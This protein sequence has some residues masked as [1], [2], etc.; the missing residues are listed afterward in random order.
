MDSKREKIEEIKKDIRRWNKEGFVIDEIYNALKERNAKK[1]IEVYKK[2]KRLVP[3]IERYIEI[4][5]NYHDPESREIMEILKNPIEYERNEDKIKDFIKR[6]ESV[7]KKEEEIFD[8]IT[9]VKSE[10]MESGLNPL[11]TFEN[12]VVYEGNKLAYTAAKKILEELG[13]INPLIIM[14]SNGTG[15]THLL[16]AIG[17]EYIKR[18]RVTYMNSEEILL[19][20]NVDLS[21]DLLLLDDFHLLLEKEDKH[22]L[23]N[24][25]FENFLKKGKQ[26]VL[27]TNFEISH[28]PL[29]PSLRAK[30]ESGI[31]IKLNSPDK[32]IRVSILKT[33]A[34][35]MKVDLNEDIIFYLSKNISN[36]SRLVSS[37]KKLIAFSKILGEKPTISMAG[38]IIKSKIYLSSGIS[39]LVEEEKPYRSI[40]YLKEGVERDYNAICITRMNPERFKKTFDINAEV[41]WLTDHTT[42]LPSIKPILE[43]IN[44][45]L[46]R[47]IKKKYII[48]LDGLDFL[49][50]KNSGDA[51]IQFIRHFID[52]LSESN[53]ILIISLNPQT[54]EE[55]YLKILEREMEI[56]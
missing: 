3:E 26:I 32:K 21:A 2:Y 8:L 47:Y 35:E 19:G 28:Y 6:R 13:S 53:S 1:F 44:F 42:E 36:L 4:I 9:G 20:K 17:N 7:K 14:G 34:K 41:Y 54:I 18:G 24:L 16:N 56:I 25:I 5:K 38:E 52:I 50:S 51:V 43:N 33:K 39:Y 49:I 15:K 27:A 46:E 11:Y 10:V 29:D 30:I 31:S 37:L 45:F 23:I 48:F 55:R 22:P 12:Y 40:S